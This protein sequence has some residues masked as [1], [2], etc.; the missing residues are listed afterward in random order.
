MSN[1]SNS[2]CFIDYDPSYLSCCCTSY[3]GT[4]LEEIY[5]LMPLAGRKK[6]LCVEVRSILNSFT[7]IHVLT[8]NRYVIQPPGQLQGAQRLMQ[9]HIK[10]PFMVCP[11]TTCSSRY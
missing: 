4:P 8:D 7:G 1:C 9:R 10:T 3:L 6:A 11:R 2:P 5:P